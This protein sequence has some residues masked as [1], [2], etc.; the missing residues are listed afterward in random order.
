MDNNK[1][2][3]PK[4]QV[5]PDENSFND[6]DILQDVSTSL[7]H[8]ST[9]YGL[10]VQEAS[11]EN[12]SNRADGLAKEIGTMARNSFNLM[13]EKGWYCLEKVPAQKLSQ[14]HNKFMQK[15]NQL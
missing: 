5:L 8:L 15:G 9:L 14:E 10:L 3:N 6:C 4:Q 11:N 13:F 7:K 1:V 2:Q 12:L